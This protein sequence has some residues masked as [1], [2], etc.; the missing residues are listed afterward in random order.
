M[1]SDAF[2]SIWIFAWLQNPDITELVGLV[3]LVF[4]C[5]VSPLFITYLLD[6]ESEREV[7]KNIQSFLLIVMSHI[8]E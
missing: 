8:I 6:V 3:L 5:K 2:P 7:L 1:D 4:V